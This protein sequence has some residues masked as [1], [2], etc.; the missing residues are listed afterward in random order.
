MD[1]NFHITGITRGEVVFKYLTVRIPIA[2]TFRIATETNQRI[3]AGGEAGSGRG[4]PWRSDSAAEGAERSAEPVDR[5]PPQRRRSIRERQRTKRAFSPQAAPA[6]AGRRWP[7]QGSGRSGRGATALL[8][9]LH[10][11]CLSYSSSHVALLRILSNACCTSADP[12][13]SADALM[14]VQRVIVELIP[15]T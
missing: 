4:V 8:V 15:V 11:G 3:A 13:I 1:L 9:T 7:V 5:T 2:T 14:A 12:V 10:V 6:P